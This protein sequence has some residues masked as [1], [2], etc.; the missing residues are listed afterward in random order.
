MSRRACS[1]V[2]AALLVMGSCAIEISTPDHLSI[3]ATVTYVS[4]EGG[5]WTLV[6]NTGKRY[7]PVN[8]PAAYQKDGLEVRVTLRARTDVA[9]ICMV[10]DLVE[11]LSI[12]GP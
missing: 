12:G 1:T 5:C 11:I 2:T 4:I 8:L 9:S 3:R 7:E 6:T 10:G